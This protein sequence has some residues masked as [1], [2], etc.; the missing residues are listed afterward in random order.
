M[1]L[2]FGCGRFPKIDEYVLD[3]LNV[4]ASCENYLFDNLLGCI[5]LTIFNNSSE[6]DRAK[7]HLRVMLIK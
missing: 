5:T 6:D 4:F 2:L 1:W 7:C 3:F